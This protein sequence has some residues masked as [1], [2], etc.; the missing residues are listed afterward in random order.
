MPARQLPVQVRAKCS[1]LMLA[2]PSFDEPAPVEMLIGADI[3][4]QVWKNKC[5]SLGPGFPSVY[6][7]VFGWVLIGPVQE[8][9]DIGA[10]AMLVSLVS[11]MESIIERFWKVE[12]PE[13]APPQF[14]EDGL[15]E[16]LFN[17]EMRKD[18]AHQPS[19]YDG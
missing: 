12:E 10:Q 8:H 13:A 19:T 7:S 1:H 9:P 18:Q 15:C 17:S 16:E 3:F 4:P 14:S 2:D 5:S 11:S 6:S